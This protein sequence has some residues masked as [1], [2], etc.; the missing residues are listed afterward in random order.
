MIDMLVKLYALPSAEEARTA[1]ARE[2]V[3]IRRS[4]LPER[5]VVVDWVREHFGV[6]APEVQAS[7]ARMPVAC[8][9]AVRGEELAGFACYDTFAAN[10]F[11]PS[12]VAERERGRGIGR[13]LLLAALTAQRDAGFAYAIIGGVGPRAFYE[14]TVGAVAIEGSTPG[15]YAGL[16]RRSPASSQ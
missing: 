6:W 11:G 4:L 7:Y 5:P 1:L 12:G 3:T 9:V 8:F 2:G 15:A 14:K 10:F 13:A 16:L